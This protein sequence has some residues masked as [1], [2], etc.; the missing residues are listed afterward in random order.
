MKDKKIKEFILYLK[1]NDLDFKL[2]SMNY[3]YSE[4]VLSFINFC[5]D[6][7]IWLKYESVEERNNLLKK[8]IK[9]LSNDELR[10]LLAII[11]LGERFCSG[12]INKYI[13]N[14]EL[15]F[16]LENIVY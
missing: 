11:F 10:K 2:S 5:K 12:L 8:D 4:E 7:E 16:I 3:N 6:E 13:K 15:I 14:K 9:A 1:N